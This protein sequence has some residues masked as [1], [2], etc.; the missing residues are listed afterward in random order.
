[1]QMG[2]MPNN[3]GN[4]MK[5]EKKDITGAS[6]TKIWELEEH[7]RN[8]AAEE[9]KYWAQESGCAPRTP[10]GEETRV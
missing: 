3:S 8:K 1:M 10:S 6:L 5:N 4:L 7:R 9:M 2:E